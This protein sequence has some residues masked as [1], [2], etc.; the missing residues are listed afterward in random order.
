MLLFSR[1]ISLQ[2]TASIHSQKKKKSF[3]FR[4]MPHAVTE[5]VPLST[6]KWFIVVAY[7]KLLLLLRTKMQL[8][9]VKR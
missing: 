7:L 4:G 6:P 1:Q 2:N 9:G 5:A 8:L 3:T